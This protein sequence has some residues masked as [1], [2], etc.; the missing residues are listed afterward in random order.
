MDVDESFS[1]HRYLGP[2]RP[3][4]N[5]ADRYWNDRLV[6][7][8]KADGPGR[9]LATILSVVQGAGTDW[10]INLEDDVVDVSEAELRCELTRHRDAGV[11]VL[12]TPVPGRLYRRQVSCIDGLLDGLQ[13][14]AIRT[15]LRGT[16]AEAARDVCTR[17]ERCL[18]RR[19]YAGLYER[20]VVIVTATNS[21]GTHLHG[22]SIPN[23]Q[24]GLPMSTNPSRVAS[25]ESDCASSISARSSSSG[26]PGGCAGRAIVR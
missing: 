20:D 16:F 1:V 7:E 9:Y 10:V 5:V 15:V 23:H 26:E 4:R 14:W 17:T 22:R 13:L 21:I 2:G 12:H 25:S 18:C 11:I 6:C 19:L 8:H 3:Q 24:G